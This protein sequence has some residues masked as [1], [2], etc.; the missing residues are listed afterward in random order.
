MPSRYDD[1]HCRSATLYTL[2]C[3]PRIASM[4]L[5]DCAARWLSM[6]D[7]DRAVARKRWLRTRNRRVTVGGYSHD[8]ERT[9]QALA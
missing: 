4:A 9:A 7:M 3:A 6:D 2:G 8:A 5:R 1:N